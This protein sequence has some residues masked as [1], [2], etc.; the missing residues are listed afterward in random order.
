[1]SILSYLNWTASIKLLKYK[2]INLIERQKNTICIT[3]LQIKQTIK[4]KL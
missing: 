2:I 4:E 3:Y 1:M